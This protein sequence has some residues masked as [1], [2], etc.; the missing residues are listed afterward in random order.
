MDSSTFSIISIIVLVSLS[1]FFSATETAFSSLNKI[2]L[3]NYVTSGDK[4]AKR[5]LKVAENFD[6]ALSAVLIGNNIVNIAA[7]SVGTIFF[8]SLF[9][10]SGVGISTIV[11]TIVV[12]IFGEVIPKSLAKEH[13]ENFALT[14][15]GILS[16][17]MIIFK[18]IIWC[19]MNIKRIFTSKIKKNSQPSVTEEELKY[20]IEEIED[21]GV[22]N[23]H[24]SELMQ[25]ALDFDDITAIEILTPRVDVVAVDINE[26]PEIIKDTIFREGYSRIPVYDKTI[27]SV[28]GVINEKD[29]IKKYMENKNVDI[30]P[31]IQEAIFVPP[32]KHIAQLL[33]EFQRKKL[34]LAVVSDQY[35]GT[36]GIITLEDVIEELVGEIWDESDEIIN[37]ITKLSDNEY[38]V[39]ADMNVYDLFDYLEID[40]TP[41]NESSQSMSAWAL[42]MFEKIPE[43]NDSFDFENINVSVEDITEQRITSF[44]V[45][46]N[47]T[48]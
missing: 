14:V 23:E 8:T 21:E 16:F 1:A 5:T 48:E 38:R 9:G 15:S 44:I 4:R 6:A 12:L 30:K 41:Y 18:P 7:A 39:S 27:D 13:P 40:D 45:K 24:E 11:M 43:K 25:S 22:L 47:E 20:I 35:G 42:G 3:R 31:L 17:L 10:T 33:K 34:H 28:V 36:L 37:E 32:K 2:R 26:N 19:L 29:F 46:L